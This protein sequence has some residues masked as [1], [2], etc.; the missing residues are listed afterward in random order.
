MGDK[1]KGVIYKK[2]MDIETGVVEEFPLMFHKKE[3]YKDF[4][5]IFYGHLLDILN[6]LGNRKIKV[7]Q[8]IIKNREKSNNTFIGTIREIADALNISTFTVQNTLVILEDK[9]VIKRKLGV[10]YIDADLVVDGRFK[11]HIMHVY[12]S[13]EDELTAEEKKARADREIKRK[14]EE[15]QALEKYRNSIVINHQ[16]QGALF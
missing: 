2:Y 7:L 8:Y 5:M 15:L 13:V 1:L 12:H 14:Q 6:D 4:E 11:G 10:I 9:E 16:N 3:K